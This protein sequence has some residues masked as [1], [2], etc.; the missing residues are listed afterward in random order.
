MNYR[1]N[2]IG[3][4]NNAHQFMV[5]NDGQSFD[6]FSDQ[7]PSLFERSRLG[8]RHRIGGHRFAYLAFLEP[9]GFVYQVR[10]LYH[11]TEPMHPCRLDIALSATQEI[12]LTD[13]A[14]DAALVG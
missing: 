12:V 6:V 14:D 8:D 4:G 10:L 2:N 9:R 1:S 5:A 11:Q 3:P 7:A 13:D